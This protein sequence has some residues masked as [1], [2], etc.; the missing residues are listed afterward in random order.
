MR[1]MGDR[2]LNN[3]RRTHILCRN[4]EVD[5]NVW[6]R[7]LKLGNA[8]IIDEERDT[9][10]KK[11]SLDSMA[12]GARRGQERVQERVGTHAEKL[13]HLDSQS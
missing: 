12:A 7:I 5:K 13:R 9:K 10:L 2:C 6:Y 11:K 8:Q 1:R 4:N 3:E